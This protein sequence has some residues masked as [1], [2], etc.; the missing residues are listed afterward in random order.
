MSTPESTPLPPGFAFTKTLHREPY[1]AISPTRPELS[2]AGRTVLITGG[3]QG[4]GLAIAR[5]FGQA[6]AAR[7][8]IIGRRPD[9]VIA[10]VSQLSADFPSTQVSGHAI[11]ITD[12]KAVAGLWDDLASKSI[13]VDVA[14]LNAARITM[15]EIPKLGTDTIWDDYVTNVLSCIDF[16]ER[17]QKQPGAKDRPKVSIPNRSRKVQ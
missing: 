13:L 10:S 1:P 9:V 16:S 15:G 11:D 7:I 6:Q 4:I 5:A 3:H 2:Q 17:L 14:V 12:R 8:I